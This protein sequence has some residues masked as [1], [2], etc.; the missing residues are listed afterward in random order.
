MI[1]K[2]LGKLFN[3]ANEPR[4]EYNFLQ[5]QRLIPGGYWAHRPYQVNVTGN[6][7]KDVTRSEWKTIVSSSNRLFWSFGP[8]A[9]AIEDKA[10]FTIGKAWMPQFA[11]DQS[12]ARVKKWAQQAEDWLIGQ[13]FPNCYANGYDWHTGLYLDSIGIDRDGDIGSLYTESNNGS[14]FPQLQQIPWHAIGSRDNEEIVKSGPFKGYA[15][16]NGLILN[17]VG[18][19]IAFRV[20]GK[21]PEF[22][23]DIPAQSMDYLREPKTP[24]QYRGFPAFTSAILDLKDCLLIQNYSKQAVQIASSIGLIETNENGFAD[25]DNIA[26]MF[27]DPTTVQ[28][29]PMLHT[30]LLSG[31]TIRYFRANSGAKL[32]QLVN[33]TPS[34]STENLMDRLI[35]NSM[36]SAGMPPEFY[37]DPKGN[38]GANVRMVIQ[39]V[40]RTIQD[41]QQLMK[42][43]AR[44]RVGWAVSKA[45]K[46]G[47][48]PQFPG[49]QLGGFLRWDFSMPAYL[50]A[51]QSYANG[52]AL[53]AYRTGLRSMTDIL[54]EGGKSL[55]KHLDERESEGINIMERMKRSGLPESWFRMIT[56]NG[57]VIGEDVNAQPQNN[58][59]TSASN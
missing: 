28:G 36:L 8:V 13:W 18:R 41:R 12:D 22:D 7:S 40:N 5:N 32:E 35:R 19:V 57:N 20:L 38:T 16:N 48:I 27:T 54:G 31:G 25:P 33:N 1:K 15:Q 44:R 11:G 17:D 58:N 24:D 4:S 42:L 2:L 6:L 52:D 30:E 21:A 23:R 55:D 49:S 45:I 29:D 53:D 50:T 43:T 9:G 47:F 34:Q 10:L 37:Y 26:S 56:P 46:S 51:D 39:K 14:G 59:E 3:K